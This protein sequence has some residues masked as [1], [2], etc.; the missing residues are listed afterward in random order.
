MTRRS[1]MTLQGLYAQAQASEIGTASG[2]V[3]HGHVTCY[4]GFSRRCL[5]GQMVRT[6]EIRNV[7]VPPKHRRKRHFTAF[8]VL[9]EEYVARFDVQAVYIEQVFEPWFAQS[10]ERHGYVRMP[11]DAL[12]MSDYPCSL[13]K[14]ATSTTTEG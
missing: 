9:C 1:Q 14:L 3:R 10:F 4:T 2:Y 13:F 11:P 7:S 12:L 6:V 5:N 8:R